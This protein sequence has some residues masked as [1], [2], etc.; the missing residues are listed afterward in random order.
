MACWLHTR[1]D[2]LPQ[3]ASAS[4]PPGRTAQQRLQQR[5]QAGRYSMC[6]PPRRQRHCSAKGSEDAATCSSLPGLAPLASKMSTQTVRSVQAGGLQLGFVL[7]VASRIPTDSQN[8]QT[9]SYL[10]TSCLADTRS[11]SQAVSGNMPAAWAQN[12]MLQ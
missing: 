6:L 9:G 5:L 1:S 2:I 12:M 4:Y 10:S 11:L 3:G 7:Q 8:M